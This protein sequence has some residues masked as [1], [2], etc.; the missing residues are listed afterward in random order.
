M[1][2]LEKEVEYNEVGMIQCNFSSLFLFPLFSTFVK[3]SCFKESSLVQLKRELVLLRSSTMQ[4]R[5]IHR[6]L[7]AVQTRRKEREKEMVRQYI[8]LSTV[9]GEGEENATGA[10]G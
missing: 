8:S 9:K 4:R 7:Q 2:Q 5:V 6:W 10:K 3:V 1:V